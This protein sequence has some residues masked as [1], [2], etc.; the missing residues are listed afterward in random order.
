VIVP[1]VI[2]WKTVFDMAVIEPAAVKAPVIPA[3]IP[4][5][6]PTLVAALIPMITPAIVTSFFVTR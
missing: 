4:V 1:I 3:V 2:T 5:L 6:T